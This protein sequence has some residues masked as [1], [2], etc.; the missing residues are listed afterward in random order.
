MKLKIDR[1]DLLRGL[2]RIQAVIERRGT[3]PILANVLLRAD[4]ESLVLAATDL[5]IGVVSTHRAEVQEAGAATLGA[6]KLF[7][8]V[9]ELGDETILLEVEEGSRVQIKSGQAQFSLLSI[10]PEEY[11]TLPTDEGDSHED[12]PVTRSDYRSF[13]AVFAAISQAD[14]N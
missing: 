4:G 13:D 3:L 14:D 11:P 12:E 6:K 10:S 8:I 9:R 5:E 7:E 1:E 2:A